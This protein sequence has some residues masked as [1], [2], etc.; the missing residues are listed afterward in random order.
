ME[1]TIAYQK[2]QELIG[3]DI[4]KMAEGYE[5]TVWKNGKKNKGWF[6]HVIE[7]YLGL[8]INSAQS[9]NFGS[10]ELKTL[11]MK[12]LKSG[13][14]VP[15][16]TMAVTMID[17]YNLKHTPFQESHL[18]SKLQKMLIC[19][20]M[21]EDKQETSALFLNVVTI[22]LSD[23]AIIAQIKEDYEEVRNCIINRGFHCLTGKMGKYIQPRTKGAGHGSTTRAFYVRTE[24]LKMII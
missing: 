14:V 12:R 9:P 24:F 4:R 3:Q 16:E 6:G 20:R 21:F 15:K 23:P 19:T 22:D 8:P 5:V 1:R 17:E 11:P 13:L 10:W 7:R 18:L 2:L